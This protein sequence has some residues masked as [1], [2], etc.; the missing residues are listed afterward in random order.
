MKFV[1]NMWDRFTGL[2]VRKEKTVAVNGFNPV[3]SKINTGTGCVDNGFTPLRK[4]E[5]G[6]DARN[7]SRNLSPSPAK[8]D[9]SYYD[10][11]LSHMTAAVIASSLSSDNSSSGS[12]YSSSSSSC[13]SGSSSSGSCGGE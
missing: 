6:I 2:F 5:R 10:T 13:D 8:R 11:G 7:D 3:M 9:D 12:S 4:V 1:K